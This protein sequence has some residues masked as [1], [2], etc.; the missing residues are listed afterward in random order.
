MVLP[1]AESDQLAAFRARD[2]E[3]F[4]AMMQRVPLGR[5]GDP[6]ADIGRPIAWLATEDA[7]F[8]TGTILMLDGGQ[9]QLR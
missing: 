1:A 3:K 4:G 8:V 5:F 9:M 6:E 7:R 2:P